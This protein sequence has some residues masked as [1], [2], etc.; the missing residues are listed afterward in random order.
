MFL[1]GLLPLGDHFQ[2][3]VFFAIQFFFYVFR[4][5]SKV[6]YYIQGLVVSMK[7]KITELTC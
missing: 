6:P 5:E 1:T 4:G 2:F 7:A 3:D